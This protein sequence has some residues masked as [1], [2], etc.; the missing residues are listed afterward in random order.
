M[1]LVLRPFLGAP[2]RHP[3]LHQHFYQRQQI[4]P[5]SCGPRRQPSHRQLRTRDHLY[6]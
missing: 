3:Y 5:L 2:I 1:K 6:G 4:R